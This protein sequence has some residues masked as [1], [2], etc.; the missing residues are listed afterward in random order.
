MAP[1]EGVSSVAV[2]GG[3]MDGLGEGEGE[4]EGEG[5]GRGERAAA[6]MTSVPTAV[7]GT[8]G[9]SATSP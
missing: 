9:L 6:G 2:T 1:F 4:N 8:S 3:K 5:D 7:T